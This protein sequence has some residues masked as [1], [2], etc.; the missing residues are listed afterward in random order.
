MTTGCRKRDLPAGRTSLRNYLSGKDTFAAH[1]IT[2]TTGT[3]AA[4]AMTFIALPFLSRLYSPESFGILS[5]FGGMVAMISVVAS[6]RYELA[7]VLPERQTEARFLMRLSLIV[8]AVVTGSLFLLFFAAGPGMLR[9]LNLSL[10]SPW[11]LYVPLGIFL[12]C[13][14][15]I[16][17]YWSCRSKAFRLMS[18]ARMSQTAVMVICQ[19]AGAAVWPGGATGLIFGFLVGQVPGILLLL[20]GLGGGADPTPSGNPTMREMARRYRN[21]PRLSS[22]AAFLEAATA[23]LPV[24]AI[25]SI[26]SPA[27]G[28]LYAIA[29][30]LLRVPV[31]LLGNPVSQVFFRRLAELR[32]QPEK[33]ERLIVKI[34]SRLLLIIALPALAVF[35]LGPD[36]FTLLLGASWREAGKFAQ[37]MVIGLVAYFV[38]APCTM[39][40]TALERLD[41]LLGWQILNFTT[42]LGVLLAGFLYLQDDIMA[43]LWLWVCREVTIQSLAMAAFFWIHRTHV[44]KRGAEGERA[45][46]T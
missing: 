24:I 36:L 8:A 22:A 27:A 7:I 38:A 12:T 40:I 13:A 32:E 4:Y 15:N 5:I 11:L 16:L 23:Q 31:G 39:G 2:L 1:V 45:E 30:R 42:L 28:G 6:G 14:Y 17:L 20:R 19:I 3:A 29:D 18:A 25:S 26:F 37:V 43:F 34:W 41:L 9:L 10:V 21:F 44:P 46:P 35:L 33:R